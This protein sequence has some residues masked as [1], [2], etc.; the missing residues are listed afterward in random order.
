MVFKCFF[1]KYR[2]L[3]GLMLNMFLGLIFIVVFLFIGSEVLYCI[4]KSFFFFIFFNIDLN[5]LFIIMFCKILNIK[6][7]YLCMIYW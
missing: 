5:F 2:I 1:M 3:I 7:K 4:V 6:V